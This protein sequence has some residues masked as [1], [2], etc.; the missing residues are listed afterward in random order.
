M[1]LNLEWNDFEDYHKNI[2][3]NKD[4]DFR[5]RIDKTMGTFEGLGILLEEGFVD[6]R[7]FAKYVSGNIIPIWEKYGPIIF[8]YR[9]RT[10]YDNIYNHSEL[11]YNAMKKLRPDAV[12]PDEIKL[13]DT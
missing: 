9:K 12:T 4:P 6:A 11:L 7:I 3:M 10:N 8:E 13:V 5:A 1:M 2:R